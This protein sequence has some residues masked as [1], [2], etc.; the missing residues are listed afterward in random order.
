MPKHEMT[1]RSPYSPE[2]LYAMVADI[3]SYPEFLPWCSGARIL[4]REGEDKLLAELQISYKIL[5]ESYVSRVTLSPDS[6]P[7]EILAQLERGPFTHLTNRWRFYPGEGGGTEVE[8]FLDLGI[9]SKLLDGM[10]TGLFSKAVDSLTEAFE[11]RA[12]ALYENA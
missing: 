10:L 4:K 7:P 5:R 9:R 8:F 1:I 12:K 3:E 11:T 6:S 2:K